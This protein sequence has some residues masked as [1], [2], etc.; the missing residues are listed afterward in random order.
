MLS[1]PASSDPETLSSSPPQ[2]IQVASLTETLLDWGWV[3]DVVLIVLWLPAGIGLALT[4][5]VKGYR[6]IITMPER[7]SMEKVHTPLWHHR[8]F[9]YYLAM[10]LS[11]R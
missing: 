10:R 1:G 9:F 6:C 11:E 8:L 4:A 2:A 7:M 3:G 5:A